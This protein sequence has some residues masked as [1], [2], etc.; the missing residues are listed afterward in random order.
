MMSSQRKV[1]EVQA[2]AIDLANDPRTN[3]KA[4]Y[5]FINGQGGRTTRVNYTL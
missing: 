3:P 2:I 1:F 4:S 5:E